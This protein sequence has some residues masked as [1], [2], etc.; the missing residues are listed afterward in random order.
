M[1]VMR[2]RKRRQG[3]EDRVWL[4]VVEGAL[5][6]LGVAPLWLASLVCACLLVAEGALTGLGLGSLWLVPSVYACLTVLVAGGALAGVGLAAALL[7]LVLVV[8]G[9]GLP[10]A[11][12]VCGGVRAQTKVRTWWRSVKA[13]PCC[14]SSCCHAESAKLPARVLRCKLF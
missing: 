3:G 10:A 7:W 11:L 6:G 9:W 8:G 4:L 12:F 13:T 14:A 5:A 1:A 2:S